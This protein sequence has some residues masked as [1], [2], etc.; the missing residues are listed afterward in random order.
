MCPHHPPHVKIVI[1][2][3]KGFSLLRMCRFKSFLLPLKL[4]MAEPADGGVFRQP[5][6]FTIFS[7]SLYRQRLFLTWLSQP[8]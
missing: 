8:P 5:G 6:F 1:I 2:R 3:K 4:A 7:T